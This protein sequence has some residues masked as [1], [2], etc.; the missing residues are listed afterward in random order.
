M[1]LQPFGQIFQMLLMMIVRGNKDSG[2]AI[3]F[4]P[5]IPI[6][7]KQVSLGNLIFKFK[8]V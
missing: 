3:A 8:K 2:E 7:I 4:Q 5:R 6:S 1:L